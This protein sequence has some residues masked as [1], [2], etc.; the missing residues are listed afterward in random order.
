MHLKTKGVPDTPESTRRAAA[1]LATRSTLI[2]AYITAMRDIFSV[3]QRPRCMIVS[4]ETPLFASSKAA[5]IRM[6]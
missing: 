6:L 5:P 4:H 2:R 3:L 1:T